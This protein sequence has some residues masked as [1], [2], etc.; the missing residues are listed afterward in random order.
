MSLQALCQIFIDQSECLRSSISRSPSYDIQRDLIYLTY[1][2]SLLLGISMWFH[3]LDIITSYDH[4][5][6]T[7]GLNQFDRSKTSEN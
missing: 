7:I 2:N 5:K 3:G 4:S 1:N 6:L